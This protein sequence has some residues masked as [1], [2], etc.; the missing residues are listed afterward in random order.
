MSDDYTYP[1]EFIKKVQHRIQKQ[2]QG[3]GVNPHDIELTIVK[4]GIGVMTGKTTY[5]LD[6]TVETISEKG[7]HTKG[8]VIKQG[9]LQKEIDTYLNSYAAKETLESKAKDIIDS[10]PNNG[11]AS[12]KQ[13]IPLSE[14]KLVLTEHVI[15]QKCSGQGTITCFKCHGRGIIACPMCH[16]RGMIRCQQCNGTGQVQVNGQTQQCQACQ[17]RGEMFCPQCRGQKTIPCPQCQSRGTLPC[18]ACNGQGKNSNHTTITPILKIHGDVLMDEMDPYPKI[19]AS[20]I[21]PMNLGKG[22]H[23]NIKQVKLMDEDD[24]TINYEATMSWAVTQFMIGQTPYK[25][26]LVGSKGAVCDSGHFMDD[27]IDPAIEKITQAAK[28]QGFVAGLLKEACNSRVSRE[29]LGLIAQKGMKRAAADLHKI[30][31]LGLTKKT[32]QVLVKNAYQAEKRITRR[33]RYIGLGIG[34]VISTF[35]NF[36]WFMHGVG[37]DV[38]SLQPATIQMIMEGLPLLTGIMITMASIKSV[39]FITFQSVMKSIGIPTKKMPPVGKAG[40]YGVM[41]NVL[42]W[43][44][45]LG[46]LY[47]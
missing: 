1:L 18:D 4:H 44:G 40:L 2:V 33:P 37:P 47:I 39:G 10:L 46:V 34:L 13:D 11:F 5:E 41:G 9:E 31:G 19:M 17:G 15:C 36:L 23:I 25:I 32:L 27:L 6:C 30:Y 8:R 14:D 22:G 43:C 28:G 42:L 26:H 20:K 24:N 29:T 3:N 35:I 21:G 7:S 12:D 38:K 45:F 16:E